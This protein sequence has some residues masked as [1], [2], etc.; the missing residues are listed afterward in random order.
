MLDI[1]WTE[2]LVIG[3][4]AIVVFPSKDLPKLLRATGQMIGRVRRMAGDFQSQFN[5]AL[6]EAEREVDLAETRKQ[7]E[8]LKGAN[9]IGDVKR[10]LNP[11]RSA[12]EDI[13]RSLT[14]PA[15]KA[16]AGNSQFVPP[17][18]TPAAAET[19]PAPVDVPPP[20]VAPATPPKIDAPP[21]V[22]A[23]AAAG[24]PAPSAPAPKKAAA[25][26]S[27][28]KK[29]AAAPKTSAA[30]APP[31]AKAAPRARKTTGSVADP[32]AKPARAARKKATSSEG[33][34]R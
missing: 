13:R 19:P 1:G 27:A 25:R 17:P 26:T 12:G 5:A 30:A 28:P 9:P 16:P 14:E 23:P 31:V 7:V 11:L 8:D 6:R 24:S 34:S 22:A 21:P 3:A 29:T 15:P 32:A 2:I 18:V 4:V 20:A 10:A 33:D